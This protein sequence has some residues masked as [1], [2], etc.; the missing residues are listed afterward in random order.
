MKQ[1]NG[2]VDVHQSKH[3]E[4][5]EYIKNLETNEEMNHDNYDKMDGQVQYWSD[6]LTT[7]FH[8]RSTLLI[9]EFLHDSM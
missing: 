3:L 6:Y 4:P 1:R 2:K 5:S 9:D 7:P 8:P